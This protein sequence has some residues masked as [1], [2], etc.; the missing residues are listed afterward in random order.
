M[1][2]FGA[3]EAGG[4]KMVCA[5]G[6]AQGEILERMSL[7]TREPENTMPEILGFFRERDVAAVGVGCFGPVLPC[8]WQH[9]VVAQAAMA[10]LCHGAALPGSR[11][12]A[13]GL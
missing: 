11:G 9:H 6:N 12:C 10:E 3:L 7:P 5:I 2:H 13:S 1:L 8:L 4:T